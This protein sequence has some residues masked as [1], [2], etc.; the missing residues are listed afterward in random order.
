MLPNL[1]DGESKL[2]MLT[3][4]VARILGC[5]ERKKFGLVNA[6]LYLRPSLGG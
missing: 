6:S 5:D 3:F 2:T 1:L 4:S